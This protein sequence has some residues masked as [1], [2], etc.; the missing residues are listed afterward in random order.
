MTANPFGVKQVAE[1]WKMCLEHINETWW[2]H[3]DL[4]VDV[5]WSLNSPKALGQKMMETSVTPAFKVLQQQT[6]TRAEQ[7]ERAWNSHIRVKV[8][9]R[10][11]IRNT[12]GK[13]RPQDTVGRGCGDVSNPLY[14]WKTKSC[15]R[16]L[17][18]ERW[19]QLSSMLFIFSAGPQGDWSKETCQKKGREGF[20]AQPWV[21]DRIFALKFLKTNVF[22]KGIYKWEKHAAS[23]CVDPS[24][25][26][27]L[28]N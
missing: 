3:L 15:Y 21:R 28:L 23:D 17:S 14:F 11:C 7:R 26:E 9:S 19:M 27:E 13:Q 22:W 12:P 4:G 10:G 5:E 6:L 1:S 24:E 25:N 18:K 20:T 2:V 16:N 8:G